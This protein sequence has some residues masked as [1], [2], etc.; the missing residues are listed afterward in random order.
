MSLT[1]HIGTF[2]ATMAADGMPSEA[3]ERARRGFVDCLAVMVAGSTQEGVRILRSTLGAGTAGGEA[4][5]HLSELRACAVTAA[6]VNGTAAHALDYD[7][8]SPAGHR[9]AVLVPAILAEGEVI[10]ATGAAMLTAYVVGFE[11]WS[12]LARREPGQLHERGWHPTGA[13]GAAAAAA[14]IANL[15]RLGSIEAVH[16]IGIGASQTGGLVANF[17]SMTKPFHA[18]RAASSGLLAARLAANGM[19]AS[20]TV[21]EHP[22]GLL[23]AVSHQG[24]VD[25][26]SPCRLGTAWRIL[27]QGLSFKKYPVCYCSHRA[28]DA[29]LDL[30]VQLGFDAADIVEIEA[31]IGTTQATVLEHHRPT[32]ALAAKFSL[33]FALACAVLDGDV[34]LAHLTDARVQAPAMRDLMAKIRV[35][36]IAERDPLLPGYS[37][38]DQVQLRLASGEVRLSKRVARARGHITDADLR[39]KFNDCLAFAGSDLDADAMFDLLQDFEELPAG[40]TASLPRIRPPSRSART[41]AG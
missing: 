5:L 23:S 1:G 15:R 38:Y 37:P 9:S 19:T 28:I 39:R 17:G 12:E 21:I 6:L 7:D 31:R 26:E 13:Y 10:G 35:A 20:D 11:V 29:I 33:E 32:T 22:Q 4:S 3:R 18:G 27:E 40:W 14:A 16:A 30:R 41:A 34:A 2:A 36:I 25:L 24:G 8:T